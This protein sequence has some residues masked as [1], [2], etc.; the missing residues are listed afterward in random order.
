[1]KGRA[2]NL[3]RRVSVSFV[4]VV[5]FLGISSTANAQLRKLNIAYTAT[6]PYQ[7]AAIIARDIGLFRKHG[8]DMTMI[9]ITVLDECAKRI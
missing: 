1:M 2:M 7:S 8:L 9:F 4:L 6:S 5:V 3:A